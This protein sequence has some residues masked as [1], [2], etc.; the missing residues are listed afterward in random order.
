VKFKN[1]SPARLL[2][3][4][5]ILVRPWLS[6][7]MDFIK[8]LPLSLG[9]SV[10]WVMV[11][12]LTKYAHFLLLKHPYTAEKLAQSFITQLFKLHSMPTSVISDK[13]ST[14]ISKLHGTRGFLSIQ[15]NISPS[16]RW[17]IRSCQQICG[18]LSTYDV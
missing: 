5:H 14:F 16:I 13:D 1:V 10:I 12:K 3:S 6:I 8:G 18:K 11:D 4:L 15:H 7:S 9:Y 17:P 2:Q